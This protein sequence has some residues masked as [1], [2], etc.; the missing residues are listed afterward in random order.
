L[1]DRDFSQF[2]GKQTKQEDWRSSDRR[3]KGGRPTKNNTYAN[4]NYDNRR[5]QKE[6]PDYSYDLGGMASVWTS[7][8]ILAADH[9]SVRNVLLQERNEKNSRPSVNKQLSRAEIPKSSHK[10]TKFSP[11]ETSVRV[12]VSPQTITPTTTTNEHRETPTE[13]TDGEAEE[14]SQIVEPLSDQASVRNDTDSPTT[15]EVNTPPADS[16]P[17]L[18][19][20]AQDDILQLDSTDNPT[21]EN[22]V[23]STNNDAPEASG[24][25]N[26]PTKDKSLVNLLFGPLKETNTSGPKS[27][28]NI[29]MNVNN[30]IDLNNGELN[31]TELYAPVNLNATS[32]V[33]QNTTHSEDKSASNL[34]AD[35]TSK[36]Q[37]ST[38]QASEVIIGSVSDKS[39]HQ[40]PEI[41]G[42]SPS[43]LLFGVP[44]KTAT[45]LP[46]NPT[47]SSNDDDIAGVSQGALEGPLNNSGGEQS[48]AVDSLSEKTDMISGPQKDENLGKT[49]HK[50]VQRK[51]S[52]WSGS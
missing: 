27:E 52:W 28:S 8:S 20:S 6:V 21:P 15:N 5:N 34:V 48:S 13:K 29:A 25:S 22:N 40:Q 14:S 35:S 45:T 46:T 2:F 33:I 23:F 12:R 36:P 43:Q 9:P 31:E 11:L 51:V 47:E 3:G 1:L 26:Q 10:P 19:I 38:D 42:M 18:V 7:P 32:L 24:I 44:P 17:T 39:H 30:D 4:N 16:S 50:L 41:N 37:L 49:E